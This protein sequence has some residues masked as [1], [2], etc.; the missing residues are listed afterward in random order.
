MGFATR[1]VLLGLVV[2][3]GAGMD[4]VDKQELQNAAVLTAAAYH[5][6][7]AGTAAAAFDRGAFCAV[8]KIMLDQRLTVPDGGIACT[9]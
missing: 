1:A 8:H 9:R 2:G 3:C 6:R 4:D 5:E 7:D